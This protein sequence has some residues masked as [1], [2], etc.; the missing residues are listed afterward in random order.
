MEFW[1]EAQDLVIIKSGKYQLIHENKHIIV[2]FM[3]VKHFN[4][5]ETVLQSLFFHAAILFSESIYNV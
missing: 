2:F 3:N 4:K 5:K 1:F